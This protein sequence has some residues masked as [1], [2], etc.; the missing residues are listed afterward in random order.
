M[1][2][3]DVEVCVIICRSSDLLVMV[4]V[5]VGVVS[6][7]EDQPMTSH[8]QRSRLVVEVQP[9]CRDERLPQLLVGK[10]RNGPLRSV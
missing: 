3:A 9:P 5:V 2:D 1:G 4:T 7:A 10:L 8:L 6:S